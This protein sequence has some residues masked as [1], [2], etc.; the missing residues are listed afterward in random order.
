VPARGPSP[1]LQELINQLWPP[2]GAVGPV[3]CW[4]DDAAPSGYR[5]VERYV[6]VPDRT[7]ARFLAPAGPR[8]ALVA[9]LLRY[10]RLRG[11]RT[12]VVRAGLAAALSTGLTRI[13][14]FET[15]SVWIPSGIPT[16]EEPEHLL[17][18]H[19]RRALDTPE[20][21]MAV[22][23]HDA[24]PN[25]K[26]TLQLFSPTGT[27]VGFAKI[28]WS[29]PTRALVRNEA[30][31]SDRAPRCFSGV[32]VP[33]VT[34]SG[35]WN[36]RDIVI[37]APLPPDVR[38]YRSSRPP[39][40]ALLDPSRDSAVGPLR[41]SPWWGAVR[42]VLS[43]APDDDSEADFSAVLKTTADHLESQYGEAL[44]LF[45]PCHGDWVPWN[46]ARS[47][48][49][50]YAFDWEHADVAMPA[51]FD[52]LHWVFQCSLILDRAPAAVA[53]A[54]VDAR[55]GEELERVGVREE[56]H[57]LTSSLYLLAMALRTYR[58]KRDG[59]TWNARLHPA[60]ADVLAR[61]VI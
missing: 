33:Q 16:E 18:A 30:L 59:G 20:A 7:H 56:L 41:A 14:G 37:L 24:D 27:P 8:P 45:V 39:M 47:G 42:A 9:S 21:V 43:L 15:M 54:V 52:Q 58:L 26:P 55:S 4:D 6:V 32:H 53:A 28:G 22:G 61:R 3:I 50:L 46:L 5:C 12:Q 40:L 31:A 17:L 25:H 35:A 29:G 1:R 36:D 10:N 23:V 57:H 34:Y 13:A 19:T 44:I 38:R 51:G 49:S 11:L 48:S 2:T 60:L